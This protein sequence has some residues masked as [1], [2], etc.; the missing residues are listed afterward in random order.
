MA[1]AGMAAMPLALRPFPVIAVA[2]APPLRSA[3]RL[4]RGPRNATCHKPCQ[5]QEASGE[6]ENLFLSLSLQVSAS[7]PSQHHCPQKA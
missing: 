6:M 5:L 7:L 4:L 3:R 2:D 1:L